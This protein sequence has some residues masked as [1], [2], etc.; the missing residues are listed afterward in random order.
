MYLATNLTKPGIIR[1]IFILSINEACII[2][3]TIF[4]VI[5]VFPELHA[6]CRSKEKDGRYS[7]EHRS[8]L[9]NVIWQFGGNLVYL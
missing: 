2:T 4:F 6:L 1:A 3:I 9:P 8:M 7:R 5:F